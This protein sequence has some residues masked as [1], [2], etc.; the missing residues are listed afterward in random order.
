MANLT[1]KDV[2]VK[3]DSFAGSLTDITSHLTSETLTGEQNILED[4]ALGDD[5]RTYVHGL[6]GSTFALAGFWNTTTEAIYGPLVGNRPSSTAT[7]TVQVQHTSGLVHRGEALVNNV[8]VTGPVDTIQTF[9]ADY[10]M[11]GV[12]TRT[13]VAL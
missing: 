5:E 8:A 7:Y 11:S 2:V 4:S 13:S 12:V 6:A 10:T 1:G 3:V 9:T